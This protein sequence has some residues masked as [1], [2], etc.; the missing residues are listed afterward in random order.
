MSFVGALLPIALATAS[1]MT[2]A[3]ASN[4]DKCSLQCD[5]L[6]FCD[7]FEN[8]CKPC[9]DICTEGSDLSD[10]RTYCRH[11]LTNI[12]HLY[13][14]HSLHPDQLHVLTIMVALTAV[15]TSVIMVLLIFLMFMKMK[16]RKRLAKKINPSILYSVEKEKINLSETKLEPLSAKELV[17]EERQESQ[18]INRSINTMM[19]QLSN[20]SSNQSEHIPRGPM[21]NSKTSASL[22]NR[23]KRLPSEDCVPNFG[24]I[25]PGLDQVAEM[26]PRDQGFHSSRQYCEVV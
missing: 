9:E 22:N 18:E 7:N 10:C 8:K 19:T 3:S 6:S 24:R 12:V 25:N 26:G 13:S 11:Y 15:M 21:R 14:S 2:T 4:I 17:K 5:E 23:T 16:K 20:N 1:W